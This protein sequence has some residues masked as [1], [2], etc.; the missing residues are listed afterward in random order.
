MQVTLS[1]ERSGRGNHL[2]ERSARNKLPC[3]EFSDKETILQRYQLET[4][5]R[6]E[7]S[8]TN[9]SPCREFSC[10]QI[11]LWRVQLQTNQP[12]ERSAGGSHLVE[13]SAREFSDKE[14]IL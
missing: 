14:T 6:V 2:V 13:R 3:R 12:V 7:S 8:A 4:N 9:K 1:V 10:K 5:H 11:T